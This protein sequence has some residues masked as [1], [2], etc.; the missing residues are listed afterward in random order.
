VD[1]SAVKEVPVTERR[2]EAAIMHGGKG[3][4]VK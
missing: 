3:L 1:S 4:Q 2:F